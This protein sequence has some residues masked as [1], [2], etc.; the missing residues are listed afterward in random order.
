MNCV[1]I[2]LT[3]LQTAGLKAATTADG[4]DMAIVPAPAGRGCPAILPFA[5]RLFRCGSGCSP[6]DSAHDKSP[7]Y[8][9]FCRFYFCVIRT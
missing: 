1:T 8:T 3:V 4:P 2:I 7:F 6:T 5:G 9:G